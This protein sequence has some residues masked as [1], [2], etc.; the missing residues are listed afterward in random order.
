MKTDRVTTHYKD[1]QI[2]EASLLLSPVSSS[3]HLNWL[4]V[5]VTNIN[6]IRI[7]DIPKFVVSQFFFKECYSTLVAVRVTQMILKKRRS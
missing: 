7:F 3:E 4:D 5:Y 6:G 2:N 1:A